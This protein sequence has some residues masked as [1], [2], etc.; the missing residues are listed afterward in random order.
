MNYAEKITDPLEQLHTLAAK[1]TYTRCRDRIQFLIY[2]KTNHSQAQAGAKIGLKLRQSQQ[3]WAL[4]RTGGLA[5]LLRRDRKS[6]FGKLSSL[7][8]SRLRAWLQTDQAH[9]LAS[10]QEWLATQ[11]QVRYSL[12]GI[13]LLFQRLKIKLKTGRPTSVRQDKAGLHAFK[14][15]SLS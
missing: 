9:T 6:Y 7:Q 1:Q 13:S 15:T 2:L 8:I 10:V 5:A 4:Y 11:L 3:L 14:K 12:G